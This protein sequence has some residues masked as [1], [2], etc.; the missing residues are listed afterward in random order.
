VRP[1]LNAILNLL[2]ELVNH[3]E[4]SGALTWCKN[5]LLELKRKLREIREPLIPSRVLWS[6]YVRIYSTLE[7]V[8]SIIKTSRDPLYLYQALP[9]IRE[10][11]NEFIDTIKK[12][13][14]TER[15]QLGLPVILC[16]VV[17]LIRLTESITFPI[18]ISLAISTTAL[19]LLFYSPQV[20]LILNS[21]SGFLIA[22]RGTTISDVFLGSLLSAISLAYMLVIMFTKSK[23]FTSRIEELVNSISWSIKHGYEQKPCL[24]TEFILNIVKDHGVD[25]AGFLKYVDHENLLKYKATLKQIYSPVTCNNS[26][27]LIN[28]QST[29]ENK[30]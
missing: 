18:L 26:T 28:S 13:Y 11:F 30:G 23:K 16:L 1:L 21:A 5:E 15:V 9:G 20:G 29:S 17:A 8:V 19:G 3:I 7:E 12:A 6:R 14:L 25:S 22:I 27:T 24:N 10:E 2:D 4:S